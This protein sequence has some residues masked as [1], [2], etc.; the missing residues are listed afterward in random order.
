MREIPEKTPYCWTQWKSPGRALGVVRKKPALPREGPR[1]QGPVCAH[2]CALYSGAPPPAGCIHL[3]NL[4]QQGRSMGTPSCYS[5]P[6]VKQ[7]GP[8]GIGKALQSL[9]VTPPS[10]LLPW[11]GPECGQQTSLTLGHPPVELGST[12]GTA[13]C[14]PHDQ[15]WLLS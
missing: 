9:A 13:S 3:L 12:G 10:A 6:A 8:W 14:L 4:R 5:S 2:D 11:P 7:S 15:H 1:D